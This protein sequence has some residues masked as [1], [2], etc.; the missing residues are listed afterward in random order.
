MAQ[1]LDIKGI[2]DGTIT[3]DK[4]DSNFTSGLY[5][6]SCFDTNFANKSTDNL[7]EGLL[8]LYYTDARSRASVCQGTGV[9]YNSTTGEISIG[10]AVGTTNNVTFNDITING[11]LNSDDITAAN[12]T[13]C[14]NLTVTGTTT[15]VNSTTLNVSD[16]NITLADGANDCTQANG[17]GIT[18]AGADACLFYD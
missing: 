4:L 13:V 14:G 7:T 5:D 17:A 2:A 11:V 9:S 1:Y 6:S 3:V 18:I 15:S 8:N 12:I 16:I 10:Q